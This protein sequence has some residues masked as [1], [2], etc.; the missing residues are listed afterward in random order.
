MAR[1]PG[2]T[3]SRA[4]AQAHANAHANG[5]HGIQKLLRGQNR[6]SESPRSNFKLST[7]AQR[8]S[9]GAS[10]EKP[11]R[12]IKYSR[13]WWMHQSGQRRG[14]WRTTVGT[15][16]SLRLLTVIQNRWAI[17]YGQAG[18][19]P[20]GSLAS[21]VRG[22]KYTYSAAQLAGGGGG[23]NPKKAPGAPHVPVVK[24]MIK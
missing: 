8:F 6:C 11:R 20:Y 2:P 22:T 12:L 23:T 13:A 15:W 4:K 19:S 14:L 7:A 18:H 5:T 1:S 9:K 21:W 10:H 16:R 24:C 3:S 17:Q